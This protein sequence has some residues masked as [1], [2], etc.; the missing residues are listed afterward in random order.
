VASAGPGLVVG[1]ADDDLKWTEDTKTVVGN[2]QAA[3][4]K[5]VRVTLQWQPGQTK[6]DDDGRTYV[7]RAQAAAKLGERVVLGIFGPAASPPATPELRTQ[8]CS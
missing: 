5:A 6:V 1:V 7:R 8:F 2:H 3:G 4:L